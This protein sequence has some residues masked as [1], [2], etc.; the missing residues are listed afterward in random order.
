MLRIG[1]IVWGVR[2]VPAAVRFWTKVLTYRPRYEPDGDWGLLEPIAGTGVQLALQEVKAPAAA[3]RRHHLDLYA[4]DQA[5]EVARLESL[6]AT[7]VE[8]RYEP[9]ADYV[10]MA[11]PDGNLFCVIAAGEAARDPRLRP[12]GPDHSGW[13]QSERSPTSASPGDP[14]ALPD[15]L[16]A[17]DAFAYR[18]ARALTILHEREL[19]AFLPV[20]HKAKASGTPLPPSADEDYQSYETLLRHVLRAAGRYLTWMCRHLDLPDPG[21][22]D[23]PALDEIER[24]AGGYLEHVLD[25]WRPALRDV[26]E[27]RFENATYTSNWGV[28]MTIESMLEHAVTH[29]IRHTFQLQELLARRG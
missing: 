23:A 24:A 18:G 26:Q 8:W 5:S 10:V 14:T 25:R 4:F 9:D 21:I 1:S 19:R 11:D 12:S 7:R 27:S 17:P 20:W 28:P 16:P 3:R 15:D 29:P 22:R 13:E 2:D 6:G